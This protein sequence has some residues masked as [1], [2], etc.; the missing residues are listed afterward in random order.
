[1]RGVGRR[2][3]PGGSRAH[4]K[5]KGSCCRLRSRVVDRPPPDE[6]A[7]TFVLVLSLTPSCIIPKPGFPPFSSHRRVASH[8]TCVHFAPLEKSARD[9]TNTWSNE[10]LAVREDCATSSF[11]TWHHLTRRS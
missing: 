5:K 7:S 11:S 8:V 1:M 2:W 6:P 4:R 10:P 3:T 9:H